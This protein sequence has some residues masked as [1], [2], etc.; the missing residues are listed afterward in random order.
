MAKYVVG[1]VAIILAVVG[2]YYLIKPLPNPEQAA[3]ASP[4]Q[5][6]TSTYATTTWSATFPQ[7]YTVDESYA[8]EGV[9]KKPIHGVKFTIPGETATGTNLSTDTGISVESLPRAKR[10]TGDIYLL[11]DVR[12]HTISDGGVEYSL[13]TTTGAAAGN[14]YEEQVWALT[15]S[16]PCTAVRYF[17]HSGNIGNYPAAGEPG[18]VREFDRATLLADF[19][20]I[21]QSLILTK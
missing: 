15:D 13:A 3:P 5:M 14:M 1:G 12:A 6:A 8:Y 11:T 19:D 10:C 9:P 21:R 18:S 20:K 17:I 2:G 4:V 16:S 7:N